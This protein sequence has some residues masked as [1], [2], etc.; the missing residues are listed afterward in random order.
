MTDANGLD[1]NAAAAASWSGSYTTTGTINSPNHHLVFVN[2]AGG[3]NP[4]GKFEIVQPSLTA[5]TPP[6]AVPEPGTLVLLGTGTSGL[7][8]AVRRRK[9]T[10]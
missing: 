1:P 3:A 7:V 8:A 5:G 4:Q 9:Q 2:S 10:A 6:P